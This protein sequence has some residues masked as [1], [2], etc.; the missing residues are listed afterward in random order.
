MEVLIANDQ[1]KVEVGEVLRR[2]IEEIV[3]ATL[4]VAAE[5][6]RTH[7]VSF[8]PWVTAV[9]ASAAAE[10]SVALVDDFQI[11][12]LNRKYRQVDCPTDVLSF[13]SGEAPVAEEAPA[14]LGDVVISLERASRQT[15]EYGHSPEREVCYL[16]AHGILHLLGFDHERGDEQAVMRDLEE[17]ALAR[18]ALPREGAAR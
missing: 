4:A 16:V 18:V 12:V 13:P 6:A 11:H 5:H 17:A 2:R 14:L 3:T 15:A 1:E 7:G 10:V 9:L 8:A